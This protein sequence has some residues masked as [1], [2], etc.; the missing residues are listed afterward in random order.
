[1]L[2]F[3]KNNN[4]NKIKAYIRNHSEEDFTKPVLNGNNILHLAIMHNKESVI[5]DLIKKNVHILNT[6]NSEQNNPLHLSLYY[7]NYSIFNLVMKK[8]PDLLNK[9]NN[10]G[11]TPIYF[12]VNNHELFKSLIA[13][14]NIKLNTINDDNDTL[15]TI[16]INKSKT[17]NDDYNKNILSLIKNKVDLNS[18]LKNLP[19][20]IAITENKY[21]IVESLVKAGANIDIKDD[22]YTTPLIMAINNNMGDVVDLLVKNKA[23]LDYNGPEGDENLMTRAILNNDMK[24]INMLIDSGYNIKHVNRFLE[25]PLHVLLEKGNTYSLDL[26][27]K[28]VYK[29]NL[30]QQN[31]DG[32][33]PLHLMISNLDWRNFSE[34]LKR[35]KLDIFIKDNDGNSAFSYIKDKDILD[36]MNIVSE[37]YL[38]QFN[39]L[40]MD[41]YTKKKC[42]NV[43]NECLNLIKKKI[44]QTKRSYPLNS[45]F[46]ILTNFR[47]VNG[48][49][50]DIGKFNSDSLHNIIYTVYILNKYKNLIVPFKY[51]NICQ[52]MTNR[53]M[54]GINLFRK[55]EDTIIYD[56]VYGY[57][58]FLYEL[59]PY[60]LLWRDRYSYYIDRNLKFYVKKVLNSTCRFIYFKLTLVPS[61]SGTHA[62]ILLYDKVTNMMERFDPYGNIPYV[63][64][65]EIDNVLSKY[66]KNIFT[67]KNFKYLSP[68]DYMGNISFQTIS[69]DGDYSVKRLGDPIGFCLAWTFWYLEMRITNPD[70][71]PSVTIKESIDK[72]INNNRT[73]DGEY[74][75]INFIR[76]YASL[77][78]KEKNNILQ[79]LGIPSEY[80]Y[81]MIPRQE[82]EQIIA[83]KLS[84]IFNKLMSD[85]V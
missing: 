43:N 22:N 39:K 7:G 15:L 67:K 10:K 54:L 12:T 6:T 51:F 3:I 75:F 13:R 42:K 60:L 30:L 56:L 35:K 24:T 81:N 69:N 26:L 20:N 40:S 49:N 57:S 16:N 47:L 21:Y 28:A 73:I 82:D 66:F 63:D 78:D 72:I 18:P 5:K 70:M 33:T 1:M 8:N 27:T 17:K 80:I 62:N 48:I 59:S 37:S 2:K 58:N 44:I 4:W 19:L 52:A 36:F 9:Q 38:N 76:E 45:D 23:N 50:T 14:K 41:V 53:D 85:R 74:I 46:Y 32:I 79:M 31:I 25:T 68:K 71:H 61:S 83:D 77:L 55:K 34:I 64:G 65:D 29:G 11:N 84:L